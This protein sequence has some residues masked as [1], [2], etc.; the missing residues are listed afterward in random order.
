MKSDVKTLFLN[1]IAGIISYYVVKFL[2]TNNLPLLSY[3]V[4]FLYLVFIFSASYFHFK[5]S[6]KPI[7]AKDD[8]QH[9]P[10]KDIADGEKDI[11]H[12]ILKTVVKLSSQ[13]IDATP[14]VIG[15]AIN[16]DPKI[17]L[18]Y[19]QKMSDDLLVV[20]ANEGKPPDINVPFFVAYHENPWKLL[21]MTKR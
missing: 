20:Y 12:N 10:D 18:A 7:V 15:N 3:S 2:D 4:F 13:H 5:Q 6:K 8:C 11:V 16:E 9:K 17:V 21:K 1:I 14:Q 19:L